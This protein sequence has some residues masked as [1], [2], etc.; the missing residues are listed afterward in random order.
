MPRQTPTPEQLLIASEHLRYEIEM[1]GHTAQLLYHAK[2]LDAST[3]WID[4]TQYFALVESF[5]MHARSLMSFFYPSGRSAEGDV[6]AADYI[7]GWRGPGKWRGFDQDRARLHREIMHLNVNRRA[8]SKRWNYGRLVESLNGLLRSFI[9]E[10]ERRIFIDRFQGPRTFLDGEPVQRMD[11][12]PYPDVSID[13]ASPGAPVVI[14][15]SRAAAS[16]G[17]L[18]R[19]VQS[20]SG[21]GT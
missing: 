11:F 2:P 8:Q 19:L 4:K 17:G 7:P 20:T 1:L 10:V 6:Y 12:Y 13:D 16:A 3:Y 15:V 9:D 21:R 18:L 14:V 5:A